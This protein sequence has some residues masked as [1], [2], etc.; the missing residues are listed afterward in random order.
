MIIKTT[1]AQISSDKLPTKASEQDAVQILTVPRF[2][3][4]AGWL[5]TQFEWK[6]ATTRMRGKILLDEISDEGSHK[7]LAAPADRVFAQQAV[8]SF[9][10]EL[11]DWADGAI[12]IKHASSPQVQVFGESCWRQLSQDASPAQWR[13]MYTLGPKSG[14]SAVRLRLAK[15]AA[16]PMYAPFSFNNTTII[17]PEF[18]CLIAY[19]ASHLCGIDE[20]HIADGGPLSATVFLS[21][22]LW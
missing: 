10:T 18:N 15:P 2:S 12:G 11:R 16:K 6:L 22:Y 17:E 19:E 7:F 8:T 21:G 14:R 3:F 5:R 9:L 1:E 13:Y 20:A 4:D